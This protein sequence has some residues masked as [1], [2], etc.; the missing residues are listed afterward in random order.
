MHSIINATEMIC[1]DLLPSVLLILII[2]LRSTVHEDSV[3]VIA[4]PQPVLKGQVIYD[5][6]ETGHQTISADP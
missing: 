5:T 2:H 3:L 1:I 6:F 4:A